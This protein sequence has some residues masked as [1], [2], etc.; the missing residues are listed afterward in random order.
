MF[1]IQQ[2]WLHSNTF[3]NLNQESTSQFGNTEDLIF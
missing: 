1:L 2:N 3:T